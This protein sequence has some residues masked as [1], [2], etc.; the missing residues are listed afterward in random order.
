MPP[1]PPGGGP[2]KLSLDA[3]ALQALRDLIGA[4]KGSSQVTQR[5]S[6]TA[7]KA[8]DQQVVEARTSRQAPAKLKPPPK[9]FEQEVGEGIAAQQKRLALRSAVG[10]AMNPPKTFDQQVQ[11][12]VASRLSSQNLRAAVNS[13]FDPRPL[14]FDQQVQQA[15]DSRRS[16]QAL[17][18]AVGARLDPPKPPKSF[19][20][21]VEEGVA[22]RQRRQALNSAANSHFDPRPLTFDQRVQ[23]A[24]GQQ[25]K[26]AIFQSAIQAKTDPLGHAFNMAMGLTT[27]LA[28]PLAVAHQVFS[29]T[30]T[31]AAVHNDEY[32]SEGQKGRALFKGLVP[33]GESALDWYDTVSGRK[34]DME[35][36][37]EEAG[38]RSIVTDAV[39]TGASNRYQLGA[40]VDQY[41]IRGATLGKSEAVHMA[42]IDRSTGMGERRF[43]I[44]S[45]MLPLRER[46]ARAD[47]ES[48]IANGR[49]GAALKQQTGLREE[50]VQLAM[51]EAY[52]AKRLAQPNTPGTAD[53][54]ARSAAY[55]SNPLLGAGLDAMGMFRGSGAPEGAE[56]LDLLEQQKD[57]STRRLANLELQ[58]Q[59]ARDVGSRKGEAG[60]A[61]AEIMKARA[62]MLRGEGDIAEYNATT[63]GD[64]AVRL[65]G[66]GVGGRM[67]AKMFFD[68]AKSNPQL[69]AS[70]PEIAAGA[71]QYAPKETRK[72]LEQVGE[73][74]PEYREGAQRGY[75][76]FPVRT[77]IADERRRGTALH[78][79]AATDDLRAEARAAKSLSDSYSETLMKLAEINSRE[80]NARLAAFETKLKEGRSH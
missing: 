29:A 71:S 73:S 8:A 39:N 27:R 18:A 28:I 11:Q 53:K 46:A 9:A 76:D 15:V 13:H 2:Q 7:A 65:A 56:R 77:S 30:K 33:G 19:Q 74:L 59:S 5:A 17:T 75:A 43:E 36:A 14:T 12:A 79:E 58:K 69:L 21:Q 57:V 78:N 4:V 44:E 70:V 47:R 10:A 31:I 51:Q 26:A 35:R 50:G 23:H 61:D 3:E 41:Q 6:R 45:R 38:R 25:K 64:S 67:Q 32:L 22:A 1:A 68:M 52:I 49:V 48:V 55:L 24:I 37:S 34:R 72:M 62:G 20:E 80:M 16:K 63:A 42:Q 54:V 66:M 40:V 60:L